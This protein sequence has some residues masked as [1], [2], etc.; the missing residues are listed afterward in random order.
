M[1]TR[2]RRQGLAIAAVA[3][4]ALPSPASARPVKPT[5]RA[6]TGTTA[7]G[8]ATTIALP[9][10][11]AQRIRIVQGPAHGALRRVGRRGGRY[12][13]T[14]SAG[15]A[16]VDRVRFAAL[17]RGR[18]SK[19]ATA[20]IRVAAPPPPAPPP[21]PPPPPEASRTPPPGPEPLP[22]PPPPPPAAYSNPVFPAGDDPFVLDD[23]GTHDD[24]WEYGTGDRFP[25][26]H[27][28]DLVNW[29]PAGTAFAA[30]PSWVVQTGD[31][32]PW[33]PSVVHAGGQYV[34]FY[35]GLTPSTVHCVAVATSPAPGGPYT[36]RGP[37]SMDDGSDASSPIG[38]GDAAM[39]GNI[40]PAPFVDS[41]GHAYLYLSSDYD[42]T[43]GTC[44]GKPTISEI[45]LAADLLHATAARR[46]LFVGDATWEQSG[47][48]WKTVE[49]P[50]MVKH[51]G[52]YYLLY[53]GGSWFGAYGVGYAT[54]SSPTGPF[55]KYT[56]NPIL[57]STPEV[58]GAG[59][60]GP[61]VTGPHGGLW[62]VY[63]GRDG[64]DSNPRRLRIDPFAWKPA[65]TPGDPDVASVAGP[66]SGP[67]PTAP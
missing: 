62:L 18:H 27:S 19:T 7:A 17:A 11:H 42:C 49:G 33:A 4:T 64:S 66:T 57:A 60:A 52:L 24:Y 5:C 51:A 34:M 65:T 45:D 30:R 3:L 13:Y 61:V 55:V 39:S 56:G 43:S 8:S 50:A 6:T 22:T 44:Q 23:G 59:G 32:H 31:W 15:F 53:S 35:T 63:H 1:L 47:Y 48:G 9:C 25:I 37:L 28:S 10:R 54:S 58:H 21:P 2:S 38:C 20:L 36:D 12:T 46:A 40:D 41:D 26:L 16:G 14:P 29:T 67:Q